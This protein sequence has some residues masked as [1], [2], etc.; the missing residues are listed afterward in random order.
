[1]VEPQHVVVCPNGSNLTA[2]CHLRGDDRVFRMDRIVRVERVPTE[3]RPHRVLPEPTVDG[4]R[5]RLPES[6]LRPEDWLPNEDPLRNTDTGLSRRTATLSSARRT[7][8]R[9]ELTRRHP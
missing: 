7:G 8:G 2:Y 1:M 5:I 6:A 3:P 4:H 9:S